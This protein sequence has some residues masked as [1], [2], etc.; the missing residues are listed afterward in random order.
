MHRYV[1]KRKI[2]VEK[3]V[4]KKMQLDKLK[5]MP[6]ILVLLNNTNEENT[7]SKGKKINPI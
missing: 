3:A 6:H 5:E 2:Q 4:W 7:R 1:S